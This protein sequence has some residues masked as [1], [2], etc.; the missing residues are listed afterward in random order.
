MTE[1]TQSILDQKSKRKGH[2]PTVTMNVIS[3]QTITGGENCQKSLNFIK[4][5]CT[6]SIIHNKNTTLLHLT[7]SVSRSGVYSTKNRVE[8][9]GGQYTGYP[10]WGIPPPKPTKQRGIPPHTMGRSPTKIRPKSHHR[11]KKGNG[12]ST[13][14]RDASPPTPSTP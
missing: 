7:P 8:G 6:Y 2:R 11:G 10:L 12:T 5:F 14:H 13:L 4:I 1:L 9:Q 3:Q